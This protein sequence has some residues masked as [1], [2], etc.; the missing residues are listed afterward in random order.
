MTSPLAK[1]L[2]GQA[3]PPPAKSPLALVLERG[4][5]GEL[6]ELPQL[7]AVWMQLIGHDDVQ[8]V[9]ALTMKRM[10]ARGLEPLMLHALSYDAERAQ[11]TLARAARDPGDHSKPFGSEEDWG[12][13]DSDTLA[14]AWH[15]L[16]DMRSRLSPLDVE[17]TQELQDAIVGAIVKKNGM[18]L[19][20]FDVCTLASFLLS[21]AFPLASSPTP[22]S[23]V[24]GSPPDS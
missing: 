15:H 7:G 4:P 3:A 21:T 18:L 11:L 20:S 12:K 23:T 24:G 1:K 6:V 22:T 5:R 17:M 2:A 9:E 14:A 19:R 13:V 8:D 10:A 16:A